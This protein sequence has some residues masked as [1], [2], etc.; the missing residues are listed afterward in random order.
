MAQTKVIKCQAWISPEGKLLQEQILV[1]STGSSTSNVVC[2][3]DDIWDDLTKEGT[4]KYNSK[5][6][7]FYWE[8][9]MTDSMDDTA[10]VKVMIECPKPKYGLF[11]EPYDVSKAKGEYAKYW[12]GK[13]KKTQENYE[14]TSTIQPKEI[15]FPGTEYV[16]STGE[17]KKVEERI[18]SRDN[19]GDITNLLSM[20]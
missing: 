12:V 19:L 15:I 7:Y 11:T 6:T 18:V 8:Y 3:I 1:T 20:F 10:T 2:L 5:K 9:D 17:I 16:D 14:R 4:Y 13:L